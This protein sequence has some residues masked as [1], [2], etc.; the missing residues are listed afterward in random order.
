MPYRKRIR[1]A[2][3]FDDP[4]WTDASASPV[5]DTVI[6]ARVDGNI[7]VITAKAVSMMRELNL[8]KDRVMRLRAMVA[9][10]DSYAEAINAIRRWFT[11]K[12]NDDTQFSC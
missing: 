6:D 5:F 3:T 7:F 2:Y 11:V 10:A 12:I 9:D 8:P 4:H 1:P